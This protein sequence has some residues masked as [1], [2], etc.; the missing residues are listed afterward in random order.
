M[1]INKL[2]HFTKQEIQRCSSSFVD[3][4]NRLVDEVNA[5]RNINIVGASTKIKRHNGTSFVVKPGTGTTT[6]GSSDLQIGYVTTAPHYH[7]NDQQWEEVT[8]SPTNPAGP[9]YLWFSCR[10]YMNK[11][12]NLMYCT[13]RLIVGTP[14]IYFTDEN[15]YKICTQ[16]F[17]KAVESDIYE[18]P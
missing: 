9:D 7:A 8:L 16:I 13:P 3:R 2:T 14:I 18:A 12:F 11:E 1:I 6:V 5:A 4:L 17:E 10:C 15:G